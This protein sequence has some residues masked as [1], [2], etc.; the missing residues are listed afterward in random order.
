MYLLFA[1]D[2]I[3]CMRI[4]E[5]AFALSDD[6]IYQHIKNDLRR[7]RKVSLNKMTQVILALVF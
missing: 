6:V 7:S 5:K 4:G 2:C 3:Q 1:F